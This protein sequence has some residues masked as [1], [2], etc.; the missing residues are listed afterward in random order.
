MSGTHCQNTMAGAV[1]WWRGLLIVSPR[2]ALI[3]QW[4]MWELAAQLQRQLP[5]G[6]T[7][8]TDAEVTIEASYPATVRAP[9]VLVLPT[10]A[11][12][13]DR[14]RC[15]AAELVLAVEIVSVGSVRTDRVLKMFEYAEA[16]IPNYWI[17]DLDAPVSLDAYGLVDGRYEQLAAAE[18]TVALSSPAPIT[19]DLP[20]LVT[21]R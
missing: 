19:L 12:T 3:H 9:D 1:S 20:E 14:A 5:P 4:A 10:A 8:L 6:L 2:A 7:A 21:P 18:G 16:G 11:I 17:V 15:D 13:A